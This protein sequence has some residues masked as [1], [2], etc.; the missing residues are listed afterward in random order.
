[1]MGGGDGLAVPGE[2]V[3]SYHRRKRAER[4]SILHSIVQGREKA[5]SILRRSDK[6]KGSVRE[7]EKG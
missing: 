3:N 4:N 7:R 1:M 2:G 5:C 6:E